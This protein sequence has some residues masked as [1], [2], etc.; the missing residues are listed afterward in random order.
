MQHENRLRQL[1]DSIQSNNIHITGGPEE[2]EKEK[3]A[4]NV[5]QEI[6]VEKFLNLRKERHPNPEA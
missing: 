6:T 2:E 5:F 3:G 1:S 4:E